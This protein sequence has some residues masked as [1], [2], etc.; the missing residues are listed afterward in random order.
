[1]VQIR[2]VGEEAVPIVLLRD[3]IPRPVGGF[4][5][6]KNDSGFRKLPVVV[7]PDVKRALAGAGRCA[8]RGLEP[9]MLVGGVID[10]QLGDDFETP[11]VGFADQNPEVGQGPIVG[12][13]ILIIGN[14]V[15]V[16]A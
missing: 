4:G 10:H 14:V 13:H 8:A 5:V 6:G 3:R 15:T 16:I 11:G 9:G 2:L 12:M 7:V 1:M